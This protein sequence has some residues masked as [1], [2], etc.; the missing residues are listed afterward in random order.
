LAREKRFDVLLAAFARVARGGRERLLVVGGGPQAAELRDIASGLGIG[1]QVTFSGPLEHDRVLDCYAA[2]D[3]FVFASPTETQGLVVVEAMAA[4]LPVVAVGAGGVAEAVGHGT[5]GLLTPLDP[6][7]LAAGMRAMID[8]VAL[9]HRCAEAG[10][11][12]ARDYAIDRI[13]HRLVGLYRQVASH[14]A[15][16]A[17]P[18]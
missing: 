1:G 9:R 14:A 6:G 17:A 12:A 16:V 4:G 8:D 18:D 11:V 10:R 7:A 5:T 2:A 13:V 3:I 15:T